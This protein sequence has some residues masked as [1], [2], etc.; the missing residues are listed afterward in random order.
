MYVKLGDL[1]H[2]NIAEDFLHSH[3]T[4]HAQHL[5]TKPVVFVD[6]KRVYMTASVDV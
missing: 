2:G 4:K 3:S 5:L 6:V 1:H